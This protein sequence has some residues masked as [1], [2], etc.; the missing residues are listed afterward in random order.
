[1]K[2]ISNAKEEIYR[3]I[4]SE[5]QKN[6]Y[7]P[8]VRE[9]CEKIGLSSPASVHR[10]LRILAEEGLLSGDSNKKRAYSAAFRDAKQA[11]SVPLLGKVAAGIPIL[12]HEN[13]EDAFPIPPLL[14]HG[15]RNDAFM[16][17][18]SGDS[19]KNA[20]IYDRDIIVIEQNGTPSDGDIVVARVDLED[21]TVKRFFQKGKEIELRPENEAFS[22][23]FYPSERVEILGCVTGLMRSY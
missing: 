7:P 23:M 8:T 22:P 20:G 18:V 5:Q 10:Y 3:F 15:I 9:I 1:M 13:R 6:G 17:R 11:E 4:L 14:L 12:A 19:M 2:K 16:L 21:V